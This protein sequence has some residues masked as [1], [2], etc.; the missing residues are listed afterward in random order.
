MLLGLNNLILF[1]HY[2]LPAHLVDE[3]VGP[4]VCHGCVTLHY[5]HHEVTAALQYSVALLIGFLPPVESVADG[6]QLL[7]CFYLP[8]AVGNESLMFDVAHEDH[9]TVMEQFHEAPAPPYRAMEETESRL[10]V[11]PI[12]SMRCAHLLIDY[13]YAKEII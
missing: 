9:V 8:V 6:T 11:C 2:H 13:C 3:G 12:S 7:I 4:S 1:L 5:E 10:P